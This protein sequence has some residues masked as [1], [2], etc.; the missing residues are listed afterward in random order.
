A[1]LDGADGVT[2]D[3]AGLALAVVDGAGALLRRAHVLASALVR[4]RRLA[5]GVDRSREALDLL[6][7]ELGRVGER[8]ELRGV[9]DLVGEAAAEARNHLLVAQDAVDA[10][11]VL[12]QDRR[13]GGGVER[14]GVGPEAE[15]R[16][17]GLEVA[18]DRPDA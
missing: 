7:G 3:R 15:D 10:G 18:G 9:A 16:V 2:T 17:L 14:L 13:E 12:G 11:G 5:L 6:G 1:V 8:R 4:E